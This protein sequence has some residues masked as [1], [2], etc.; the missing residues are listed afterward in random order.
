MQSQDYLSCSLYSKLLLHTAFSTFIL[1]LQ[2]LLHVH[3]IT[4]IFGHQEYRDPA[5]NLKPKYLGVQCTHMSSLTPPPNLNVS[6][7]MP[8]NRCTIC[9][10]QSAPCSLLQSVAVSCS[11]VQCGAVWCS[12]LQCVAVCSSV[13]QCVAVCCSA[14]Q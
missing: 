11:V 7:L 9:S 12:V 13:L 6:L 5:K 3:T 1:H 2:H 4:T 10:Q 14:L 8:W